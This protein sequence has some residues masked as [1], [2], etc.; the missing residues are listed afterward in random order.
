MWFMYKVL[1][2]I[3]IEIIDIQGAFENEIENVIQITD[4]FVI[5]FIA[6]KKNY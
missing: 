5:F 2:R 6:L 1:I 3:Q 4:R